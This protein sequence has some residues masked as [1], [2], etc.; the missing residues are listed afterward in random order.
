M[1]EIVVWIVAFVVGSLSAG[2]I[3]RL[4]VQDTFP[5]VVWVRMKWDDLTDGSDWNTLFHCHWCMS[6]WVTLPI[7]LWAWLSDL[8][9]SWWV[10]NGIMAAA[11]VAPMIVERDGEVQ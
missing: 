1:V 11:Y 2:R 10:I 8:H 9:A 5:P 6:F 3:T 7:G 4:L